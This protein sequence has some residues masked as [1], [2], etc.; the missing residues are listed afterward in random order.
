MPTEQKALNITTLRE[1]FNNSALAILTEYRGMTVSEIT[2]LRRELRKNGTEYHVAKNTL[3]LRAATELGWEGL[4]AALAGPTAV[5]FVKEDLAGGSKAVMDFVKNSK[6]FVVKDA[7]LGGKLVGTTRLE[8]ITKLESKPTMI[9]KMLGSLNAPAT[10]VALAL[11][12]VPRGL[13]TVLDAYRKKLEEGA[14]S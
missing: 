10:N 3:L 8:A 7:I 4:D 2:K 13:V 6:V 9:S 11:N 5:A 12:A 1:L 14:A